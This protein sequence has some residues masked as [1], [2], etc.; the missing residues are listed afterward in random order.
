MQRMGFPI[1]FPYNALA[2]Q[3]AKFEIVFMQTCRLPPTPWD[4][5]CRRNQLIHHRQ[6]EHGAH[7]ILIMFQRDHAGI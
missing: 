1:S 7:A 3:T 4:A 6:S 2:Q 5:R